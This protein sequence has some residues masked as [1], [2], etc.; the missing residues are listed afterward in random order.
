VSER[1]Y[2]VR[3]RVKCKEIKPV[4]LY[5]VKQRVFLLAPSDERS[6]CEDAGA[7]RHPVE[8]MLERD[9]GPSNA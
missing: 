9:V 1:L 3:W 8:V 6:P 7:H 2:A 4:V 5:K